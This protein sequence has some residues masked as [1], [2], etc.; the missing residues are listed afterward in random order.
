[1]I[2][3]IAPYRLDLARRLGVQHVVDV[4]SETL[5]E[6]MDDIDMTEGFDVGLEMSGAAPAMRQMMARMNNGGKIALLGIAP[7][8]FAVDWNEIIFKMLTVKGIYGREMFETWYKMIALV[9][10]GLDLSDLITHRMSIDDY[11]AGF[12][13]MLSGEAGKVVMDWG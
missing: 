9:Q 7:T 12:A 5:R 6:V 13:A 4:S 11:E 3:D 1:M 8:A 10:S 2:T